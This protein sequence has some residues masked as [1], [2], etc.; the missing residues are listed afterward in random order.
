MLFI[1]VGGGVIAIMGALTWCELALMFPNAC[2]N[3]YTYI[4]E[5]F[6]SFPS[7]AIIYLTVLTNPAFMAL[8][9][10]VAGDYIMTAIVGQGDSGYSRG[11]AAAII[12][13][14]LH[15]SYCNKHKFVCL[16]F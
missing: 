5:A 7:F 9:S 13:M 6:G 8:I 15:I 11:I 1:W 2:G 14:I 10:I 4:Y 3:S 16:I 12:G